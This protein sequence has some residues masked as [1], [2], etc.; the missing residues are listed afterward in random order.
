MVVQLP[1][2]GQA[3]SRQAACSTYAL[4]NKGKAMKSLEG[5]VAVITG[6]GGGIGREYALLFAAEG[7]KII[8]NDI[9]CAADGHGQSPVADQVVAE[10]IAGGG[11]A[12]ANNEPVGS[13]ASATR[14]WAGAKG[15]EWRTVVRGHLRQQQGKSEWIDVHFSD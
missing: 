3:G 2:V 7:A 4:S 1:N 11:E 6:A 12:V 8:V 14:P 5:K 9:G 15:V 10:I 13:F